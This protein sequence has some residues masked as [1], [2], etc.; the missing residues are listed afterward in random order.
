MKKRIISGFIALVLGTVMTVSAA[1][2]A[3]V[4]IPFTKT[5]QTGDIN[6]NGV[7][8][9]TDISKFNDVFSGRATADI[10]V[11]DIDSNGVITTAD[12]VGLR[13][14]VSKID[15]Q[16]ALGSK[17]TI[18][19]DV[20]T[21]S[22]T[23]P[24]YIYQAIDTNGN[25]IVSGFT[26]DNTFTTYSGSV[27]SGNALFLGRS[28]N[29]RVMGMSDRYGYL[30]DYVP[31]FKIGPSASTSGSTTY[32][33]GTVLNKSVYIAVTELKF[34]DGSYERQVSVF[35][36]TYKY[37]CTYVAYA[38]NS[39]KNWCFVYGRSATSSSLL[40]EVIDTRTLFAGINSSI[41]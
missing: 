39:S 38:A 34:R 10:S 23:E 14:I 13:R 24:G 35:D 29:L 8:D 22:E 40:D 30:D 16:Y 6:K 33:N 11:A 15:T 18:G 12:L 32:Y 37:V 26:N 4:N 1:A 27:R 25:L 20:Y 31:Y 2:S 28:T 21:P 7:I 3:A 5:W 9:V 41:K 36:S 19:T 17:T